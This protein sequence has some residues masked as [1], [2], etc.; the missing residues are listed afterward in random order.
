MLALSAAAGALSLGISD[1]SM[2]PAFARAQDR[3][4]DVRQLADVEGPVVAE[5]PERR[6]RRQ[7]GSILL[8]DA[9]GVQ[10]RRDQDPE[11]FD[12]FTQGR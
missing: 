12:A 7:T 11:V 5:E 3:S 9:D 6:L 10:T 2:T 4:I 1:S 8:R